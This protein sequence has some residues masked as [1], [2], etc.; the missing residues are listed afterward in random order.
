MKH[1]SLVIVCLLFPLAVFA[2]P[3]FDGSDIIQLLM[4]FVFLILGGVLSVVYVVKLLSRGKMSKSRSVLFSTAIILSCFLVH[5]AF[6]FSPEARPLSEFYSKLCD[7]RVPIQMK[8]L[9]VLLDIGTAVAFVNL[10]I[11]VILRVKTLSK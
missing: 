10:L 5:S 3:H 7:D 6:L 11:I 2:D 9:L 8:T 4:I 1:V